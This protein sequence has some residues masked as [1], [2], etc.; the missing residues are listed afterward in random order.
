[1]VRTAV[2]IVSLGVAAVSSP[3][4]MAQQGQARSAC[5]RDAVTASLAIWPAGRIRTGETLDAR[6]A[7]GRR[8]TCTGGT[9]TVARSR[10]CRWIS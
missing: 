7:C 10:V 3:P 9:P 1:M 8:L 2:L 5:P 6:H 4:V